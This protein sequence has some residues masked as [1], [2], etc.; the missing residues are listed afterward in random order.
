MEKRQLISQPIALPDA[1]ALVEKMQKGE[2]TAKEVVSFYLERLKIFQPQLNAATHI[3]YE[4]AMQEAEHPK[5]GLLSGIPVSVK[6]TFGLKN[7]LVTAGSKNG[8]HVFYDADSTIVSKLKKEGAI[9]I[10]RSNVPEFAMFPETDNIL[11]GRTNNPLN[12]AHT[13]GGSSGGEGAMVGSACSVLGV[14]SDIGG[15]IRYPAAFC[16]IVGFKPSALAVDK[17]GTYPQVNGFTDNF[18][19]LGPITRSVRDARL[20]YNIIANTPVPETKDFSMKGLKLFYPDGYKASPKEVEI[21][22][23][24]GRSQAL[25]SE[26]GMTKAHLDFTDASALYLD[27]NKL[28]IHDFETTMHDSLSKHAGK[29]YNL[30]KEGFA[31]L[32]G[33]PGIHPYL[34]QML[35]GM[36]LLRPTARQVD[37]AIKHV[38]AARQKYYQVLGDDG[39]LVLPTAG[40]LAPK[41]GEMV[42]QMRKPGVVESMKPT[43][44]C[45]ILDL[46]AITLPAWRF[47]DN[48]TGLVPGV[49]L[50][51]K[52]GSEHILFEVA[53][54]LEDKI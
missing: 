45:N 51:C 39:I 7:E 25:L 16:G 44:F 48:N 38:H 2:T 30:L 54:W 14:G 36:Q 11:Y 52:P 8:T 49:M 1:T 20:V 18:L 47:R 53:A 15:S 43:V 29:R 42:A 50:C 28:I 4:R 6:E 17:T 13:T 33:N 24:V 35:I 40:C 22:S 41:H 37:Q 19:A 32:T 34:F 12:L 46:P 3:Y 21:S 27:F 10:A 9:I 23:A 26:A 31:Q 5:P